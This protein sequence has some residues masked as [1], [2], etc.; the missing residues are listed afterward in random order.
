MAIRKEINDRRPPAER[1]GICWRTFSGS[2]RGALRVEL[3]SGKTFLLPYAHWGHAHLEKIHGVEE[4]VIHFSSHEIRVEGE[5]LQ[6]LLP[7]LQAS[8][9]ELLREA[10]EQFRPITKGVVIHA[11]HLLEGT[12]EAAKKG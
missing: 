4:L 10:Q 8:N 5:N 2:Q 1:G 11:I 7:E 12:A 3:S 6:D 9:V